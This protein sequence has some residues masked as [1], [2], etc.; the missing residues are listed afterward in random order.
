MIV[1]GPKVG[2]WVAQRV[3][4]KY[5]A[6]DSA[7]IGLDRGGLVAGVIYENWNG[8]SVTCHIAIE[9][10]ITRGYLGAIFR[11]PFVTLGVR[12]ILAPVAANNWKSRK[13]VAKMGFREEAR[14]AEAHP[15]GDLLIYTLTTERCKY[16]GERYGQG[17]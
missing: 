12:K 11:Y 5:H 10:T 15:D 7:A 17:H 6:D 4:G 14:I 3:K 9:S 8:V 16:L 2:F 1:Q 13:M